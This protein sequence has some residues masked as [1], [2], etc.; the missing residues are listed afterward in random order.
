MKKMDDFEKKLNI[1]REESDEM[2]EERLLKE[3]KNKDKIDRKKHEKR[4]FD[5]T[6]FFKNDNL[7]AS[8]FFK[9]VI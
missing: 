5:Q 1:K 6:E 9:N 2:L 8:A 7:S 3:G 4:L